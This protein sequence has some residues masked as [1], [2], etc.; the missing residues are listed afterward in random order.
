MFIICAKFF[1]YKYGLAT[2]ASLEL[3][4]HIIKCRDQASVILSVERSYLECIFFFKNERIGADILFAMI[5][6]CVTMLSKP[7][8]FFP[9]PIFDLQTA[10]NCCL[11]QFFNASFIAF[12]NLTYVQNPSYPTAESGSTAMSCVYVVNAVASAP[13][14]KNQ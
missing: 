1:F 11:L 5:S 14:K 8:I 4:F 10:S 6:N 7:E 2:Q 9:R 13:G 12:Q 3:I